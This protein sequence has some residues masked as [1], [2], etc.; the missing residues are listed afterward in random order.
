MEHVK[1]III[2]HILCVVRSSNVAVKPC[3]VARK[4]YDVE[5]IGQ[6]SMDMRTATNFQIILIQISIGLAFSRSPDCRYYLRAEVNSVS[7]KLRNYRDTS[8]HVLEIT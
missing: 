5:N 7:T 8:A 3:D 4:G 1:V 2:N 6:V